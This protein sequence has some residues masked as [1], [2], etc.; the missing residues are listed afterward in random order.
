MR[1]RIVVS[2]F[3]AV[4]GVSSLIAQ[5]RLI[6]LDSVN[7]DFA[8]DIRYATTDNFTESVLYPCSV[9]LLKESAAH[10]L[11]QANAY[12]M[13]KGYRILLFDCYR[14]LS[15][16]RIMWS[17]VPN[18]NY[19]ANPDGNGSIHN[20]GY[21]VDLGLVDRQ[22]NL[23]DMGTDYDHFGPE[24]HQ[25]Y[26]GLTEKQKQNREL[27]QSGMMQFGFRS[28][29]TEWWHFTYKKNSGTP[30]DVPLPCKTDH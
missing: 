11:Q 7:K 12:F 9:C 24:A 29:R 13:D 4:L 26:P 25:G 15:I 5:E 19:V 28:I 22:G 20:R 6:R 10:A 14:P 23:L 16:Q 18:P 2:F 3:L 30:L 17:K 1:R 21:A 27:L 8:Y